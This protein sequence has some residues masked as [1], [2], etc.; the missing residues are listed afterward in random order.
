MH[1]LSSSFLTSSALVLIP[2]PTEL[3]SGRPSSLDPLVLLLLF[4]PRGALSCY[5]SEPSNWL[6]NCI[7]RCRN[8]RIPVV[9][10]CKERVILDV[11]AD[12]TANQLCHAT[13][14]YSHMHMHVHTSQ[15]CGRHR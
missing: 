8:H 10:E 7:R 14:I 15:H 1:T 4:H 6:G 5:E 12:A 3:W 9:I 11:A 13:C 2:L